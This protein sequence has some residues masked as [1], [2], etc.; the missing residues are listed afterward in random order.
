MFLTLTCDSYGRVL[1]D[2]TPVDPDGYD[3]RL[4]AGSPCLNIGV[5]PGAGLAPTREY[6]HPASTRSRPTIGRLDAGAFECG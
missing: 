1:S 2:G 3:Y 5:P 6:A 4:A